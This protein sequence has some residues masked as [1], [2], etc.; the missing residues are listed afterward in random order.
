MGGFVSE[1]RRGRCGISQ[2]TW[3]RVW[4]FL[5]GVLVI[6]FFIQRQSG[7]LFL[8]FTTT[9]QLHRSSPPWPIPLS[10]S[11]NRSVEILFPSQQQGLHSATRS[12]DLA[13]NPHHNFPLLLEFEKLDTTNIASRKRNSNYPTEFLGPCADPSR[14]ESAALI[15][16]TSQRMPN[17]ALDFEVIWD[18][19]VEHVG[20]I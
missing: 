13:S 18:S 19:A 16:L 12:Q 3:L 15:A 8:H 20:M 17:S 6:V 7:H 4:G 5:S 14:S 11:T 2:V 1:T 10:Q 9:P